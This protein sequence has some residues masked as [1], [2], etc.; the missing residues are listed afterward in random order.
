MKC[1]FATLIFAVFFL[2]VYSQPAKSKEPKPK[3]MV[4]VPIGSFEFKNDSVSQI[5]SVQAFWMSNE[6]TNREYREF[7]DYISSH[8]NDTLF[9]FKYDN[10]K[11]TVQHTS[12][13]ELNGN[14]IDT[15][16]LA[17]EYASNPEKYAKYKN[18]FRDKKFDNYPV[19]GVSEQS[20]KYYCIWRTGVENKIYIK[21]NGFY[22]NDYRMPEEEEWAYA[23]SQW[24]DEDG[25][26]NDEVQE[27]KSGKKNK[28]GIYNMDNNV[29]EW[30]SSAGTKKGTK[31]VKGSSW[32]KNQKENEHFILDENAETSDVG[33][34]IVR[35]YMAK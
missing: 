27:V 6:I 24:K 20:A 11:R 2:S 26:K 35:T 4:L 5:I 31:I 29:S 34:R 13:K 18:Y 8:P 30:T 15:L 3:D 7:T 23:N 22:V 17:K 10:K 21:V 16:V 14:L 28:L 19:V 9:W 33:F 32:K 1:K 12:Y 25:K